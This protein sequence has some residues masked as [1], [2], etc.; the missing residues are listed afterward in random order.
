MKVS[1]ILATTSTVISI[2]VVCFGG[3][4]EYLE[5][6]KPV[7]VQPESVVELVP[8]VDIA[9]KIAG[10]CKDPRV[11]D[12]AREWT[13][14]EAA[15]VAEE[16]IEGRLPQELWLTQLC[17]E[18]RYWYL[19]TSPTG[20]KGLGQVAKITF[21]EALKSCGIS[22]AKDEDAFHPGLNLVASACYANMLFSKFPYSVALAAYVMG[23]G[24]PGVMDLRKATVEALSYSLKVQNTLIQAKQ[25]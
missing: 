23:P 11:S 5:E 4:K 8:L 24:H 2:A 10:I 12:A 13:A 17:L 18:S 1:T 25:E 7:V 14:R 3:I 16:R 20:P 6:Q 21:H 22:S 19:A 15:R 9:I